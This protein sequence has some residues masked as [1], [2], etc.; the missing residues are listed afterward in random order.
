[1]CDIFSVVIMFVR[2]I[3]P[4][5]YIFWVGKFKKVARQK[6]MHNPSKHNLG[7]QKQIRHSFFRFMR[8]YLIILFL[9]L[10]KNHVMH[11][12]VSSCH[13]LEFNQNSFCHCNFFNFMTTR[14]GEEPKMTN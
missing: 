9:K 12:N 5:L 6:R 2:E 11:Q 10:F 3:Y 1:M 7:T 8:F 13:I 14:S 4:T